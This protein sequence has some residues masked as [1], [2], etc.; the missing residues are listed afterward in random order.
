MSLDTAMSSVGGFCAGKRY[1]ID[2]QRLSGLGYCF[3]ASVPP[4]MSTAAIEA[5]NIMESGPERFSKLQSKIGLLRIL[6]CGQQAL[7]VCG[8]EHS[9]IIHLRLAKPSPKRE[10]DEKVL[11]D[12][13]NYCIE[14]GVAAVTAKYLPDE[15]STPPSRYVCA[16]IYNLH[17]ISSLL[18][19]HQANNV[20]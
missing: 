13:A 7:A 10:D 3:S 9:P 5:L 8:D 4:M 16:S 11:N 20:F 2:H 15:M 18:I 1:V 14:H 19:Q 12:V 6:L 17:L